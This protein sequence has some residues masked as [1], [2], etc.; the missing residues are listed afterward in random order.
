MGN[1]N[2]F[3]V[4]MMSNVTGWTT[5]VDET[6]YSSEQMEATQSQ[7]LIEKLPTQLSK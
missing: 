6:W 1:A 2:N 7:F 4:L 3:K 5:F